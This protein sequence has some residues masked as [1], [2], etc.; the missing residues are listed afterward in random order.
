MRATHKVFVVFSNLFF[1]SSSGL[2][3]EGCFFV[4]ACFGW[5]HVLWAG[6]ELPGQSHGSGA[7]GAHSGAAVDAARSYSG[8]ESSSLALLVLS[9]HRSD[10]NR[11]QSGRISQQS[12]V[13]CFLER[14]GHELASAASCKRL[15]PRE[16]KDKFS[17]NCF[18][19]F[20][21]TQDID[22]FPCFWV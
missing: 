3:V 22:S 15:K 19:S 10:R 4:R 7:G 14:H 9:Q 17:V 1:F 11:K 2:G 13:S 12:L 21:F 16:E 5:L 8:L 20:F 18:S 6:G